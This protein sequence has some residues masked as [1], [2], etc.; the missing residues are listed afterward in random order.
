[1]PKT[2]TSQY[3]YGECEVCDTPL[4]EQSIQQD[5]WGRGELIVI[6]N[7]P[8]GVCPQCGAKVVKAE[9]GRH[10]AEVLGNAERIATTP[11]MAVPVIR[12]EA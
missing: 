4:Q 7:V 8:A 2:Q 9:V 5:F 1:M 6:D 10:I 11:R 12:L 3:D